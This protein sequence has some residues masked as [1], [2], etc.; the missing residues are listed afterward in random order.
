MD[1]K[2]NLPDSDETARNKHPYSGDE[3]MTDVDTSITPQTSN[4]SG[5]HSSAEKLTASRPEFGA[6]RGA[7]PVSGAFG[8]DE[9]HQI[10]GRNA[11]PGT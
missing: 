6:G 4:K 2:Q 11:G 3:N 7:Q 1:R 5:K 10:T 8:D 9:S